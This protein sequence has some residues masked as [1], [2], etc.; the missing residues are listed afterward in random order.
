MSQSETLAAAE[1]F[2]DFIEHAS[3]PSKERL[4]KLVELLDGLVNAYHRTTEIE[5]AYGDAEEVQSEWN[6]EYAAIAAGFPELGYYADVTDS[7]VLLEQTG[8]GDAIDDLTDIAREMRS[9]LWIWRNRTPAEAISFFR[10]S[11]EIHWGRH[12]LNL[13]SHLHSLTF[14]R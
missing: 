7:R 1:A 5:P 6:R 2:Q 8:V 10:A 11:Y 12:L 9:F 3:G 14:E 13:R 4:G